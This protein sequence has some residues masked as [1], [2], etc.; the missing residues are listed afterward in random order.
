MT[1][2]YLP[3][4]KFQDNKILEKLYEALGYR[5]IPFKSDG[6]FSDYLEQFNQQNKYKWF[7][8][9]EDNY[10]GYTIHFRN[11]EDAILFKLSC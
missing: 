2:I 4:K 8:W 10:F 5:F 6:S 7:L 11:I 1:D 3:Y 9:V